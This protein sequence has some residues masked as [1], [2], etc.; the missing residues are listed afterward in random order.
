MF[1]RTLARQMLTNLQTKEF[2]LHLRLELM[3]SLSGGGDYWPV[4][5]AKYAMKLMKNYH[6]ITCKEEQRQRSG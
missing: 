4:Y 2:C 5:F 3:S 1:P 6:L